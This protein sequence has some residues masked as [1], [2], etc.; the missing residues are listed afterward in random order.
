M[1]T[2]LKKQGRSNVLAIGPYPPPYGGVATVIKSLMDQDVVFNNYNLDIYRTGRRNEATLTTVQTII[3]FLLIIK[4]VLTLKLKNID[5]F[6]IHTASRLSF[7]RNLPYVMI[8]KYLSRGKVILHIHGAEFNQFFNKAS[9]PIKKLIKH[10]LVTSDCI[11]VTSPFWVNII[12]RICSDCDYVCPVPNGFDKGKFHP[13]PKDECR[14]A[15]NLPKDKKILVTIGCL[16]DYKGH[17]YLIKSVQETLEKRKDTITYVIGTGSLKNYLTNLINEY[18]LEKYV[19]LAGGNKPLNEIPL[20]INAC[21]IFVLPSLAEGNPTVMFEAMGCGKPFVGTKVGGIPEIITSEEYG[22]L[23][24]SGNPK[25]L[26]GKILIALEKEW[27]HEK[28]IK[29]AEDFTWGNLAKKIAD[30]YEK[31]LDN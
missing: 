30:I 3:E 22:L 19:I 14:D 11:I 17:S 20:W 5:I 12:R 8:S 26:A 1:K 15:L 4:F 6:H 29:Y 7:L 2:H 28:I 10:T 27:D 31:V 23:C 24:E 25:E 18:G 16:E 21:D 9:K 13:I